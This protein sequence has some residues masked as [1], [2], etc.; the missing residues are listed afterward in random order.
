MCSTKNVLT[1]P[2]ST[3]NHIAGPPLHFSL[4]KAAVPSSFLTSRLYSSYVHVLQN[5]SHAFTEVSST[6]PYQRLR[7]HA[8]GRPTEAVSSHDKL[9]DGT[10]PVT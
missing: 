10:L 3:E 1:F 7:T 4:L 9:L 2:I 8:S 5:S 6:V